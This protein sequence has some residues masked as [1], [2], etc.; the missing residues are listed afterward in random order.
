VDIEVKPEWSR[1]R[2]RPLATRLWVCCDEQ[3][4]CRNMAPALHNACRGGANCTASIP[5]RLSVGCYEP[6]WMG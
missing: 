2:I 3:I 1:Y 5:T 4:P 6:D